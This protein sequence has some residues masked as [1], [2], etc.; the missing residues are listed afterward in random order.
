MYLADGIT[1]EVI[2]RL[3]KSTFDANYETFRYL[4]ASSSWSPD[5]EFLALAAKKGAQDDLVML[6]D[7]GKRGRRFKIDL[8]GVS[9]P[10]WS[11]GRTPAGLHRL[12]RRHLGPVHHQSRWHAA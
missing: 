10:S 2:R 4:N 5:G 11:P 8:N 12:R 3:V 1:G 7:R 6:N 9:N